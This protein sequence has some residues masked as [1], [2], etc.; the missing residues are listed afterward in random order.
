[1]VFHIK[2]AHHQ[3]RSFVKQIDWALS[4]RLR[5]QYGGF[6]LSAAQLET[7]DT[8]GYLDLINIPINNGSIQTTN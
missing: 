6:K 7:L 4:V 8:C 5:E 1:M 2:T 3:K